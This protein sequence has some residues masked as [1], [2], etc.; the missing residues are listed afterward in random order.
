MESLR[1]EI[2]DGWKVEIINHLYG[3][4]GRE[5]CT[6]ENVTEDGFVIRPK[7]P[8]TNQGRK[9]TTV[10]FLWSTGIKEVTGRKVYLYSI[11]TG[12]TSRSMP[13][14]KRLDITYVFEPPR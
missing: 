3:S 5:D 9:F 13:G 11:G 6:V 8:W 4:E 2:T 1:A 7:R 14:V 10:R 12:I